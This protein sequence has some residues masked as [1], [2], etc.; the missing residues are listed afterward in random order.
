MGDP[1]VAH[2]FGVVVVEPSRSPKSVYLI[3]AATAFSLLGDQLLYSVLPSYYTELGLEPIQVGIILSINRWIRLVTNRLAER[4]CRRLP[5]MLLITLAFTLGSLLAFAYAFLRAFSLLLLARMLWGLSWSFI[6]QIGVMTVVDSAEEGRLGRMMGLYS[7]LSRT[8]SVVGNLGGAVGHDLL[9]FTVTLVIFGL[10]SLL[11]VPLGIASRRSVVQRNQGVER[12]TDSDDASWALLMSGFVVGSVGPG[13]MMSTL[14]L[15]LASEIGREI[16]V[17]GITV[18]VASLTGLLLAGRWM[19]ELLGAPAMGHLSDRI[20]RRT[21][22]CIFFS[23]GGCAMAAGGWQ[24]DPVSLIGSVLVL[25][26]C[27]GGATVALTAEAG[28]RGSR[29]VASYSTASDFGSAVGPILGWS[30][31]QVVVSS[32][33]ILYLGSGLYLIGA[34]VAMRLERSQVVTAGKV[35]D[36]GPL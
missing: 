19:G 13:L 10:S 31:Q 20:G 24:G 21:S 32:D 15:L 30:T 11:A 9:G 16:H 7:G 2:R 33:L 35:R 34:L 12:R 18:G 4:L 14:G 25:F 1:R 5:L 17:V 28:S 23:I 26:V 22:I 36:D 8:G 29:A 3:G 6:R 27:G